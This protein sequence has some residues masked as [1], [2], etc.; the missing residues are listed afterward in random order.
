[1]S[2]ERLRRELEA[3]KARGLGN[4]RGCGYPTTPTK[5]WVSCGTARA[6]HAPKTASPTTAT[7]AGVRSL[8]P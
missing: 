8:S 1:M 6:A 2:T 3:L 4:C 5:R 7:C